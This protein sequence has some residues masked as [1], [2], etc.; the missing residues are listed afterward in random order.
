MKEWGKHSVYPSVSFVSVN[1]TRSGG[2]KAPVLSSGYFLHPTWDIGSE[3]LYW[4]HQALR[5]WVLWVWMLKQVENCACGSKR[6]PHQAKSSLFQGPAF[7]RQLFQYL[8]VSVFWFLK[9][10]VFYSR[11]SPCCRGSGC[12]SWCHV[13]EYFM[14]ELYCHSAANITWSSVSTL[15]SLFPWEGKSAVLP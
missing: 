2:A 14:A 15:C 7:L 1:A 11:P 5:E 12:H 10:P 9:L 3:G 8:V 6:T 13:E 4:Q